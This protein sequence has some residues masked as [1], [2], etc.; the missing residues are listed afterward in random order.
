MRYY[1]F[2]ALLYLFEDNM[3]EWDSAKNKIVSRHSVACPMTPGT[4]KAQGARYVESLKIL[5]WPFV[6][7]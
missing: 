4:I 5:T 1:L 2:A 7:L 3:R 6:V